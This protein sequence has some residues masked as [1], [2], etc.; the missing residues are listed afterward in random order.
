M[1]IIR[2]PKKEE[3]GKIV[4]RPHLDVSKLN[5]MVA[6]VL[7]DVK[8]RGDDAVKGYELKF[9][10]VDLPTLDVSEQEMEEAERLVSAELK[11]AIQLA[12]YNIHA[13][14]EAQQFKGKKVETQPGVTCWQESIA[15]EKVGLYIPGGTAPLFSTVLMLAT[16]AKIAGCQGW[17]CSGYRSDG[18]WYGVC[19]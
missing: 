8:K 15:I 2:Y 10:H 12:H 7:A 14:H 5:D 18:L 4:E 1:N 6:A 13:F 11:A 16:P 3:W 19:A 9:D 17:W